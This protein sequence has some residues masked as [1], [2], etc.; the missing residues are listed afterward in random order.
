M[1][2][3]KL[4]LKKECG[5]ETGWESNPGCLR[6]ATLMGFNLTEIK[7]LM[8]TKIHQCGSTPEG[9]LLLVDTG[10]CSDGTY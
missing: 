2:N 1:S 9:E 8:L 3:S 5:K 4:R 7:Q 6:R 10:R